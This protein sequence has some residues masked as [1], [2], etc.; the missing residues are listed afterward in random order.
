MEKIILKNII[1]FLFYL[2][3]LLF[4]ANFGISLFFTKLRSQ[5]LLCLW[6]RYIRFIWMNFRFK[7]HLIRKLMEDEDYNMKRRI[8]ENIYVEFN[9]A[10]IPSVLWEGVLHA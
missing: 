1:I 8:F 7:I 10:D 6:M 2:L 5:L 4:H 3:P 9:P